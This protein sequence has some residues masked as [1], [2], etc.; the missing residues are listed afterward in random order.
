MTDI[1]VID[2]QRGYAL[3]GYF[4][5]SEKRDKDA[6]ENKSTHFSLGNHPRIT[7]S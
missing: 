5:T 2:N 4:T 3:P 7:S 1:G 6:K